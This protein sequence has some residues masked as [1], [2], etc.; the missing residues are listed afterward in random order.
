MLRTVRKT[1]SAAAV[2]YVVRETAE[3]RMTFGNTAA[4]MLRKATS[5]R[6]LSKSSFSAKTSVFLVI[7]LTTVKD[8]AKSSW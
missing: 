3:G 8:S 5:G 4:L 1:S 6:Q 7:I 2:K